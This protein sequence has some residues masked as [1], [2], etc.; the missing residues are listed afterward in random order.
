MKIA[1]WNTHGNESI[2][3]IICDII[4][5]KSID[6]FVLAEYRADGQDLVQQLLQYNIQLKQYFTSGCERIVMFGVISNVMPGI[7]DKY[8]SVQIVDKRYILCGM[9]LPSQ[10]YA[11]HQERRNIII[12][13]IVKDIN[14]LEK[15]LKSEDTILVGDLNENPYEAGCL[16]ASKFHGIPSGDDSMKGSRIIMD[17]Q[18]KMFYNPMWNLFGDFHYPP[19]TYYYSGNDVNNTYWNVFDQVMIRPSLRERFVNDKLEILV[20]TEK[21][22]FVDQ[23]KHPCKRISDHLP[24]IFEIQEVAK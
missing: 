13:R 17:Q 15:E 1:F 5:E 4:L 21:V 19:G 22:S 8:Y 20:G 7:Q 2:N 24:I 3:S 12:D 9:H 14:D 16:G 23:N 6:I 18:F 10:I 11:N